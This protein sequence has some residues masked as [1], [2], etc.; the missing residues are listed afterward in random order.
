MTQEVSVKEFYEK[1][2]KR[3][4]KILAGDKETCKQL[5]ESLGIKTE[6]DMKLVTQRAEEL[7]K[8][9]SDYTVTDHNPY[10]KMLETLFGQ[11]TKALVW[12]DIK[13]DYKSSM[14]IIS[15]GDWTFGLHEDL[16]QA[17]FHCELEAFLAVFR[18]LKIAC[19]F[20]KEE[21]KS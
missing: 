17:I 15:I 21:Q 11:K 2:T 8:S 19:F 4:R 18:C 9:I 1:E 12:D 13:K 5:R 10:L 20:K 3:E 14:Y 6:E 16:G 7:T